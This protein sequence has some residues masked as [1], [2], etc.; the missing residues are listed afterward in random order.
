V[1]EFK[2]LNALKMNNVAMSNRFSLDIKKGKSLNFEN[3]KT[4][5]LHNS[6]LAAKNEIVKKS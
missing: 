6:A 4:Q 3:R 5:E 2:R 1:V